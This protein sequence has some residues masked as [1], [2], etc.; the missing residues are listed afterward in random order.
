[1]KI[2]LVNK[3]FYP[4][5]GDCL[6]TLRLMSLLHNNGHTV[7]PFGMSHPQNIQTD[8]N[9]YFVSYIDF[10]DE[11]RKRKIV[12]SFKVASRA[13]VN[14]EAARAINRL[15]DDTKPDLIHLQNIHHQLT[16]SIIIAAAQKRIPVVWTLH[17]FILACPNDNFFHDGNICKRCASGNNIHAVI[18]KCKKGSLGASILAAL[19]CTIYHR[20]RLGNYV[21][22]FICPSRFM[23]DI[24]TEN[25][26][27]SSK[28]TVIPNF[29]Q[30]SEIPS[31]GENYFLYAGRMKAEKGVEVLLNAFS[32]IDNAKLLLA[33]DGPNLKSF[34]QMAR[35]LRLQNTKFLGN[36][37][38][39]EIQKL[40][41]GCRASI[42]PSII[43]DNLPYAVMETMMAGKA[44]IASRIGGIPEMI[45]HEKNGLLF[46][47]GNSSRL[48]QMMNRVL[49]DDELTRKLGN[50]AR[51][52]AISSYS[53]DRHYHR[54]IQVYNEALGKRG[55][56]HL[57]LPDIN[58]QNPSE[59]YVESMKG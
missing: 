43:Y 10:N 41:A 50:S 6:Y 13:I 16:P 35:D 20:M 54:L 53:P 58:Y 28:I 11:L 47:P 51:E 1:M 33:G 18:N 45:E 49:F 9:K 26:T 25:G 34:Q 7:I 3:Y 15:I 37:S 21:A 56:S 52:K 27:P 46:E 14:L 17:D 4:K 42:V 44:T 32:K 57:E 59:L 12:N 2:I 23:A 19:E 5:G 31:V 38:P 24:L 39:S 30:V 22:K 55:S 8:Y 29:L 40:L 36:Q 48:A